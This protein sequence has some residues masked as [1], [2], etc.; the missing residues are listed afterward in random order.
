MPEIPQSSEPPLDAP[1]FAGFTMPQENKNMLIFLALLVM[2]GVLGILYTKQQSLD[3][4]TITIVGNAELTAPANKAVITGSTETI[5]S[6]YEETQASDK[7]EVTKIQNALFN[8][9]LPQKNFVIKQAYE[10]TSYYY[11]DDFPKFGTA[12]DTKENYSAFSLFEVSL[13]GKDMQLLD[14]CLAILKRYN[15]SPTV[16]YALSDKQPYEVQIKQK[17]IENARKQAESLAKNNR[18]VVA[19]LVSVV[20]RPSQEKAPTNEQPIA[21]ERQMTF[22]ASYE[23]TY[24]LQSKLFPF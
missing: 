15:T 10:P 7:Y 9:G 3:K 24:E 6:S 22:R 17:A 11:D 1:Q 12:T 4:Q 20:D 14:K 8:L 18:L 19:R 2:G 16:T 23:V 5:D 21:Q 13:E